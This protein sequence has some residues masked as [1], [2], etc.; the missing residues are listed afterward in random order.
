MKRYDVEYQFVDRKGRLTDEY[1]NEN[2]LCIESVSEKTLNKLKSLFW[3]KI[4]SIKEIK[5]C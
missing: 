4:L 1:D 3:V 5:V 2:H